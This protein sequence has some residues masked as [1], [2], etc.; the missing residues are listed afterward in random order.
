MHTLAARGLPVYILPMPLMGLMAPVTVFSCVVLGIAEILGTWV[1]AKAVKFDTPVE[2]SMVSGVLEPRTGNPC[3]LAPEVAAIDTAV[4]QFF[5]HLGLRCGTG[6]GLVDAPAP[7]VAA[8][9]ERTFKG[10]ISALCG[11]SSYPVGILAGGN[12]FSPEQMM[13]DLDIAASE[14][15]F[16]N[17][18]A[19]E[20]IT[21]SV[22]LIRE[23]GIGAFFMVTE[24]TNRNFKQNIWVPQVFERHKINDPKEMI[25]P[26][27]KA[28]ERW[29]DIYRETEPYHLPDDKAR[30]IDRIV[31]SA[32]RALVD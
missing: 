7:G 15:R 17:Q 24:H 2:C 5:R 11:E 29:N 18:F 1:C 28:W 27:A 8:A 30:E 23:E 6:V 32:K 9:Y 20:D 10:T 12:V 14:N 22:A 4:A 13:I 31:E 25:D 16:F 21:D 26:V 3:F 19:S